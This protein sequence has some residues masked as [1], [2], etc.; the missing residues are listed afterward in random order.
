M[1]DIDARLQAK[2]GPITGVPSGFRDLDNMT[3]GLQP[4]ELVILAARP[5]MEKLLSRSIS[6]K[7]SRR[8]KTP[9]W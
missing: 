3:S 1:K 9:P 4:S 6:R 2:A 8:R 5:S 7:T